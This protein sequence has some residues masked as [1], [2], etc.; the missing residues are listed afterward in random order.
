MPSNPQRSTSTVIASIDFCHKASSGLPR[1]MRYEVC[2]TGSTIPVSSRASRKAATCSAD[3]GRGVPLVVVLRE[4]LNGLEVHGPRGP[5]RAIATSGDRHVSTEF[6]GK[7]LSA[8]FY[9]RRFWPSADQLPDRDE[10]MRKS[11]T[12]GRRRF[13]STMK[14]CA[15]QLRE[16]GGGNAMGLLIGCGIL[17]VVCIRGLDGLAEAV[18]PDRRGRARRPR[19]HACFTSKGNGWK[20]ASSRP[21]ASLIRPKASAG[22]RPSGMTKFSGHA[23]GR[24]VACWPWSA[25]TSIPARLTSSRAEGMRRRVFEFRKGQWCVEG[26]SLDE[27]RPDEAIGRGQRF[28]EVVVTQPHP[29]RVG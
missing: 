2:A 5:D 29:R 21:S 17:S 7:R 13:D 11:V 25:S 14:S 9:S 23:T 15:C 10:I 20:P 18:P 12:C 3:S 4:E 6:A 26:K 24:R 16:V 1:L 22:R 27:M 8:P 19:A 28:E